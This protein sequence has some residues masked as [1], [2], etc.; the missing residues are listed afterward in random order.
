[1]NSLT[2]IGMALGL[3]L[4][5]SVLIRKLRLPQVI[6]HI[7]IG[8]VLGLS[9]L[10]I[11][12]LDNIHSFLPISSIA[13]GMIGFLI[14]GELRWSRLKKIGRSIVIITAFETVCSLLAVFLIVWLITRSIPFAL[15][16]GS[17][18]SATAPGGTTT[19]IQEYRARGRLTSTLF[20]VV[21][22]DDAFAIILYAFSFNLAK[23]ML[24]P[25]A[26]FS[27]SSIIHAGIHEIG[28]ALLLG[29]VMASI[30]LLTI[31]LFKNDDAKNVLLL[32][33]LFLCV[34]IGTHYQCSIILTTMCMG[35]IIANRKPNQ[36]RHYFTLLSQFTPP[37]YIL[38][39][40]LVGARLQANI[41]ITMG[42]VGVAYIVFR[43]LGKLVG[44]WLGAVLAKAPAKVSKNLGLC[45][46]SQAGVALGLAIS[47]Y[48]ELSTLSPLAN[49]T[50]LYIL[51]I[52]TGS[53]L[54][55][56]IVGPIL[57]KLA[58]QRAG[59]I[60]GDT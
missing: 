20:G 6:G 44:S 56:Q 22:M 27:W 46:L 24:I 49:T 4:M 8:T 13:L 55:F 18:A 51:N 5:A 11:F 31:H 17:L 25:N 36:S 12:N 57:T 37:I 54:L 42:S 9:G 33:G 2:I 38:F 28:G 43:T 7:I 15:I 34:G 10:N 19:V 45:L 60:Q 21:G 58:L 41:L 29:S 40:I 59:E 39:F 32:S 47:T 48:H 35:I 26:V 30:I 53:T 3:G 16:L 50:G 1:M 23:S 14:G 52:I